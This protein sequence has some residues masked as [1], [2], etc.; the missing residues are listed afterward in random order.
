MI[1]FYTHA[2]QSVLTFPSQFTVY[3][4]EQTVCATSGIIGCDHP[5]FSSENGASHFNSFHIQIVWEHLSLNEQEPS[6]RRIKALDKITQNKNMQYSFNPDEL[7]SEEPGAFLLILITS[8]T[9]GV[10]E[11]MK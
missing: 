6:R 5:S 11:R 7:C 2:V 8:D 4:S 10:E 1:H 9:V 3:H